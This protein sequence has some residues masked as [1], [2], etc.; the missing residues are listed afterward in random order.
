MSE[1]D[2]NPFKILR[3]YFRNQLTKYLDGI[4]YT[5]NLIVDDSLI[6]IVE[7]L[8]TPLPE[9]CRV[10]GY[11]NLITNKVRVSFMQ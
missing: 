9:S 1:S 4:Q 3:D 6:G 7:H 2:Q 10:I 11:A 5:K 8:L